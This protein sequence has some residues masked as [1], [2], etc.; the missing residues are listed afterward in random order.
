MP[1]FPDRVTAVVQPC[2]GVAPDLPQPD[3]EVA[4]LNQ[5]HTTER[6]PDTPQ[7]AAPNGALD[8][9]LLTEARQLLERACTGDQSDRGQSAVMTDELLDRARHAMRDGALSPQ[10]FAR[11]L[12]GC[13]LIRTMARLPE[14][15]PD[16]LVYD[17]IAHTVH[18]DLP[19]HNAAAHALRGSLAV[20]RG[21]VDEALDSVVDAMTTVELLDEHSVE[22]ALA[23][24]DTA[25]LLESLG[26]PDVAAEL[27]SGGAAQFGS[28]DMPG[29]EIMTMGDHARTEALYALWL[30]RAGR[31]DEARTWFARAGER[32]ATALARW[33]EHG[34]GLALDEDFRGGLH[35]VVAL[36]DPDGDHEEILRKVTSRIALPGQ[37]LAG[38]ALVRLL[39]ASGRRAESDA[40]LAELR[41]S[42]RRFQLGLPLRL[43]LAR[44]A[45]ELPAADDDQLSAG[46]YIGA[47]ES[48]LWF[49]H[50]TRARALHARLEYERLR[51]GRQPMRA[52]TAKDPVT[53]LPDRTVLD[54]LLAALDGADTPASVAMV[55]I[56][57]LVE[58]NERGSFA[59]GDAALRAIAVVLRSTVRP[60]DAVVRYSADEFVVLMPDLPLDAAA[61]A[62]RRVVTAVTELPHDR[63]HGATVSIGVVAV[64]PAEGGESILV[65]ADDATERAKAAGG[66]QVAAVPSTP[67]PR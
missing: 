7:R 27:Y 39:A 3:E 24:T 65:R 25:S 22:R 54:E 42:C 17:L 62:M 67:A 32:G 30:E 52:L 33:N 1:A 5:V 13:A 28:V 8:G 59:D 61:A 44:G 12:R 6:D 57:E 23:M 56:D 9:G 41:A 26:L 50:E 58:I 53:G 47:L 48:E 15:P 34:P 66:N 46:G 51:R 29:Y 11:V 20:S 31:A 16:P 21:S 36:A 10:G 18:H 55:D 35:A 2:R 64:E 38:L 45:I 19:A 4:A 40:T 37:I 14:L 43:A 60:D 63:G 49:I